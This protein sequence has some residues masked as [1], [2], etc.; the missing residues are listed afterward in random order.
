MEI[1]QL[2]NEFVCIEFLSYGGILTKMINKKTQQNYLLA[3]QNYK[4]Y[5][6]N[7]YFFGATI[8]RNAGRTFPAFYQDSYGDRRVL[9]TNEGKVHLHG[10]KSGLHQVEWTVEKLSDTTYHLM[11]QDTESPY[12]PMKLELIYRLEKNHFAIQM[13]GQADQPTV[14]NLTNHSYFNLG[15]EPT[16]EFHQLQTAPAKIQLI[17][18]QFVPTEEYSEMQ[19]LEYTPFNFTEEKVIQKALNLDTPLSK[20]CANGIDLAYCFINNDELEPKIRLTDRQRKNKLTI[21]SDQEACIIYTLNK[22]SNK[23]TLAAGATIEKYSGIT[24][25]MQ[26]KPNYVHTAV[27]YLE[28]DYAAYTIYEIE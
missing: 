4:D 8:G 13:K 17:D 1:Y 10:G 7:P 21:Y 23:V 27:D 9:D 11:F 12:D 15:E 25:E 20:I 3:Y 5:L 18:E 6:K 26:R 28:T 24:F 19:T 14:C 2:E 16:I 22:L